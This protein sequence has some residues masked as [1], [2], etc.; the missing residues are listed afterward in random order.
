MKKFFK[1]IS[2]LLAVFAVVGVLAITFS[3]SVFAAENTTTGSTAGTDST[4][5]IDKEAIDYVNQYFAT[6]EEKLA[7]M[8]LAYEKDGICLY[9][10]KVSGEVAY[11]NTITGEKLFT[12]PY[13]VATSTGNE[14][15]KYEIL[16]Q[17]I[18][19]FTDN[20]G[21][22][23]VFNSF[24]EAAERGQITVE[25]IKNGIRV[26]YAIGREQSKILVPRLISMERFQEMIIAPLYEIFGDELYNP[27]STD[28]DVF[29][30][31]KMLSYFLVYSVDE[32]DISKKD[33][34]DMENT[35]GG[36]YDDLV[37]SEAQ[38]ARALKKFPIIETMPVFVFDPD[39]SESELS[40]AESIIIKYCPDYSYEEL[41]YDHILTEYK[42]DDAN[43]PVFR[44]ALE[45]K[46]AEDGL[47]VR[48]PANGI[49]FNESLYTLDN[50]EVL[51]YMGAGN[52]AYEGYNFFPDGSGALFDFQA[53]NAGQTRAVS[54]NVYGTDFAYHEIS[55][56]Y[57]KT[58]RYP[59]FGV[60]EETQYY[61]YTHYNLD[62][63]T[64][65]LQKK[66]AGNIVE[67][68]EAYR[69]DE[70]VNFCKGQEA[71]LL[72]EYGMVISNQAV[73]EVSTEKRGFV[74]IIEEG[75][76]LAAITT[77]HAGALSD[78]NTVRMQFTPRPKDSYVIS[79]SISVG[80]NDE[81]TV[82]SD[83]KYVGNY[84]MKYITLSSASSTQEA[85]TTYDASW[86]GMA[87]AYRDYLTN[88]GIISKITEE[89]LV[90][91]DIPLYIETLGT[92]ETTEKILSIPVTVMAPLTTFENVKEI[93]DQLS[94]DP[95][96][97]IKN[98]NFKLTGYANGGMQYTMPGNLK[99]EQ[100]VGGNDG[101]QELLDYANKVS[102]KE[103]YNFGVYPDF[104]FAY[105][106]NDDLFDGHTALTHNAKT[107]DDRY[108]SK[109][110]YSATQ[111]KYE[112]FYEMA[113]SPAYFA[114]F[115]NKLEKNYADK[116]KGV[117]GISV[118]TLGNS[119]NSDFDEDE[120]YN[121]EDSKEFTVEAFKHFKSTYGNVMTDGGNA[122]VWKYV[123]H[124]LGV[125]LD[126]SR[127][128]FA[129]ESVPF[130]G[131]VLHGSI[132]FAGEPLNMEGD[133]RYA[134]LKAIENGASPYFILAYQN[135][136]ILKEDKQLSKYYSIQ[137]KIWKDDII[138]TYNELNDLL[139]DVQDKYIVGHEML[140]GATR[141]P[142][143]DEFEQDIID[144]YKEIYGN[145]ANAAD[146]IKL[147][148]SMAAYNA[149]K[150]G[151]EAEKYSAEAVVQVL[152]YYTQQIDRINGSAVHGADYYDNLKAAYA[153]YHDVLQ[154]NS[155]TASDEQKAEYDRM[156]EIYA[157]ITMYNIT[158][159]KAGDAYDA[160]LAEFNKH[161]SGKDYKSYATL[162][163][164][165][166]KKYADGKIAFEQLDK[167]MAVDIADELMSEAIK[168]YKNKEITEDQLVEAINSY[169]VALLDTSTLDNAIKY[170]LRDELDTDTLTV[171]V[172]AL[173]KNKT[174]EEHLKAFEDALAAYMDGTLADSALDDA[175]EKWFA[176]F[177]EVPATDEAALRNVIKEFADGSK[178]QT[179]LE[180]AIAAYMFSK[181]DKNTVANNVA[182]LKDTKKAFD[183][184]E[185]NYKLT[186][187]TG[188][189]FAAAQASYDTAKK[190]FEDG[191]ANF[192]T[193]LSKPTI[194]TNTFS[195]L[196]TAFNPE[197]DAYDE[198]V[199]RQTLD[200][201]DAEAKYNAAKA[202]Y[203]IDVEK[204]VEFC[205]GGAD[206][207]VLDG[208]VQDYNK[209]A[210]KY[211]EYLA[212]D[213]AFEMVL[214]A[215][216]NEKVKFEDCYE[217]LKAYY[218]NE[219]YSTYTSIL[220]KG[221][222]SV[223]DQACF[224]QYY[225]AKLA[226]DALKADVKSMTVKI[227]RFDN[228]VVA[229]AQ[230]DY[231]TENPDKVTE[232][233]VDKATRLLN[234]S[235]N[236][237]ISNVASIESKEYAKIKEIYEKVLGYVNLAK[238]AIYVLA[239]VE[240]YDIPPATEKSFIDLEITDDMPYSVKQAIEIAQ[241]A[242]YA[243]VEDR[244]TVI[245]DQRYAAY[246]KDGNRLTYTDADGNE[247]ELYT[248]TLTKSGKTVYSYGTYEAGYQY[249]TK[250]ADGTF[251]MYVDDISNAG[252]YV[253]GIMVYENAQGDFGKDVYFTVA[254][255]K[256]TYYTKVAEGVFVKKNAITY[257][258]NGDPVKVLNDGTEIYL[259]G[260]VYFSVNDDGTYVR[261]TFSKCIAS[262]YDELYDDV[263][264]NGNVIVDEEGNAV[265]P[266]KNTQILNIVKA[267]QNNEAASDSD[268]FDKVLERIDINKK[269]NNSEDDN[270]DGD[271]VEESKY[272]TDNIVVVTYGNDDG[273][274][275]KIIILNYNN[276]SVK[277]EYQGK[278][279][280]IP[281]YYYVEH[282]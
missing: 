24:E 85:T 258:V 87:V 95:E 107:I 260:G 135:T 201:T 259:D 149:R 269:L 47:S 280:T 188:E 50:I 162:L 123:D 61:T 124:I 204:V 265:N 125:S 252:G 83:R 68:I 42:A 200:T 116:Y 134:M 250:N 199:T 195:K 34:T 126:S 165:V 142:D 167:T 254:G 111:Q 139:G 210:D 21:Q 36:I 207:T 219:R 271:K 56:T 112:N 81:W 25:N 57:Q 182:S 224:N 163:N 206:T 129:S 231:V 130:I 216:F 79:D 55:G 243:I 172:S 154:Y 153:A 71:A 9:V 215:G 100:A 46:V 121:R 274:A 52:S 94:K 5:S 276:Y 151:R 76:A 150:D 268:I 1:L 23:R 93:Y 264:E 92:I 214:D 241:N 40:H 128:N 164:A 27:R 170:Y 166:Y 156:N 197:K 179:D 194:T 32:L 189:E 43:P 82:V 183:N 281:A 88:N 53:L 253:D 277:V 7:A 205:F 109:R 14:A 10:D 145:Q 169:G 218:F 187:I 96:R 122:Y 136:E 233:E 251:S 138:S 246:D 141:V 6:P 75:D 28:P 48:L 185:A 168:S 64:I 247:H 239:E 178:N 105:T 3:V 202:A 190:T 230:Y 211:N 186:A 89:D 225:N 232:E 2:L 155:K 33:R 70:T 148:L 4:T 115:Y 256:Y 101:F 62:D 203:D 73:K 228:Y 279:Y 173:C 104:D 133:L 35:Y 229:L 242:H 13:D 16:S 91:E 261:Y 59:V 255:G 58:I 77:Y 19:T 45:Y 171:V 213:D 18:V 38:Y 146:L 176:E 212:A 29:D 282:N 30:V 174:S 106:A 160:N 222:G 221:T 184:A 108:A 51:P 54:G 37:N 15:T 244:Y 266:G 152:A 66:I 86:F 177:N 226:V 103:D 67:A 131:V 84:M 102:K 26:E 275:Y 159:K 99:F 278:I 44:L 78:Y 20:K 69:N 223:D 234:Q 147:E 209:N 140:S 39:A 191:V 248:V 12:N 63:G 114:E 240:G 49:R 143:H 22:E 192:K 90:S 175:V 262:C 270:D 119:L 237:A 217:I 235:R 220:K 180:N 60:V 144:K 98:I 31:Q 110:V 17:I 181:I 72:E 245:N 118:S 196:L 158:L 80:S 273:S 132:N 267:L 157:I 74:C 65:T 117:I 238:E 113:I 236:T 127:Y 120:P 137:Y 263:D 272:S 161:A 198:S 41:E 97:G 208:H 249:L 227:G 193:N 11:V 8:D 257:S